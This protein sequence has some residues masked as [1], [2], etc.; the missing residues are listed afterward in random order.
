MEEMK[1]LVTDDKSNFAL[2]QNLSMQSKCL[3]GDDQDWGWYSQ[4]ML[5]DEI[6]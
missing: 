2:M 6:H 5:R 1:Y 4:T 3:I